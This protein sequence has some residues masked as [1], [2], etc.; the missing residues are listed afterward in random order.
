VKSGPELCK[1]WATH[2]KYFKVVVGEAKVCALP[3]LNT[4]SVFKTVKPR[5]ET[6]LIPKRRLKTNLPA[7]LLFKLR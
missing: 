5:E 3:V 7:E 1:S 2:V 4:D 6:M